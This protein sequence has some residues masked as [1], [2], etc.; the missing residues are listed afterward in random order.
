MPSPN[1]NPNQVHAGIRL[2][3]EAGRLASAAVIDHN[4]A[5]IGDWHAAE[6]KIDPSTIMIDP[7]HA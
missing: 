2:Q 5:K 1:P 3:Q 7:S 4:S 6:G